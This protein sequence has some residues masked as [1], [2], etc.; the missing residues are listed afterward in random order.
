R[1][2]VVVV[3]GIAVVRAGIAVPLV[4]VSLVAVVAARAA[5]PL[6]AVARAL[7]GE[8]LRRLVVSL[9]RPGL[10]APLPVALRRVALLPVPV[11]ALA[12]GGLRL[13]V[14][15]GRTVPRPAVLPVLRLLLAR[16]ATLAAV[17]AET[18]AL[19][20]LIA[21]GLPVVRLTGPLGSWSTTG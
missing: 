4:T 15:R 7:V 2:P 3:P 9:A 21:V 8:R 19:G 12:A 14:T 16:R 1:A 20:A 6:I 18:V 5:V 10:V 11:A 17:I 13:T